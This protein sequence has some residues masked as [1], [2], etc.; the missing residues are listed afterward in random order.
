MELK[1]DHSKLKLIFEMND[2]K[3]L[4]ELSK[5]ER[6]ILK[7]IKDIKADNLE[8]FMIKITPKDPKNK[9]CM[10]FLKTINIINL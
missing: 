9:N 4:D 7:N 10:I 5:M 3:N 2:T 8:D 1:K 6:E